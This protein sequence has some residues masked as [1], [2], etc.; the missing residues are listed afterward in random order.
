MLVATETMITKKHD[1]VVFGLGKTGLSCARFLSSEGVDFCV[2]DT[3]EN[4]PGKADLQAAFPHIET[5]FGDFPLSVLANASEVVLS[6]GVSPLAAPVQAARSE[7]AAIIGDLEL[8]ANKCRKPIV[9]ITGSNAKSTVTSLVGYL[10]VKCGSEVAVAGNIGTPMLD[11]V[12]QQV[13]F[14]VLELSSFQLDLCE[15]LKPLVSVILNISEDH[16]DRYDSMQAYIESKHKIYTHAEHIVYNRADAQT[17]PSQALRAKVCSFGLD[18]PPSGHDFGL[19]TENGQE[20]LAKGKQRLIAV[21]DL[22]LKGRHNL[23]NILAAFALG[24]IAGLSLEAMCRHVVG[25]RG[26]P[27]RCEYLGK[28]GNITFYNDSKG[29]N[30]GAAVAALR[31]LC[32]AQ[33]KVVLIAGGEGKGADFGPLAEAIRECAR[34]VVLI[35]R[36]GAVIADAIAG[37]VDVVF[38]V[39]LSAALDAALELANQGDVVLLS[40]ACASFDMFSNFEDRG[41]Q[42]AKR[43]AALEGFQR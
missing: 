28:L 1:T 13:D 32:P 36:D 12:D 40:P 27:H 5:C 25:F 30:V 20:Y 38:A 2:V 35:G 4:P 3:R 31:G 10:A 34:A 7:G 21:Q 18:E 29:T 24:E 42:F 15:S 16:L 19:V 39:S 8:F 23:E 37:A 11:V 33:G 43:V 22:T 9:A 17:F 14:F 41:E 26:L 6:P